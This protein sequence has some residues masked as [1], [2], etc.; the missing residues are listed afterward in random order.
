MKPFSNG[1]EYRVWRARNC[2]VC[3]KD[4]DWGGKP[5]SGINGKCFA[6]E[7]LAMAYLSDGEI[8][9]PTAKFIGINDGWYCP[10][11]ETR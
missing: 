1:S 7:K 5:G 11:R 9:E 2:D 3:K 4:Y 10:H 6:E 8:N